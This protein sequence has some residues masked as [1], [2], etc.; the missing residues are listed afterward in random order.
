MT[1]S[2]CF[3][4]NVA[5]QN[6][7]S[8]VPQW[9]IAQEDGSVFLLLGSWLSTHVKAVELVT[10]L[11]L[12]L[13]RKWAAQRSK[14]SRWQCQSVWLLLPASPQQSTGRSAVLYLGR[15]PA[16]SVRVKLGCESV[17][18]RVLQLGRGAGAT[19]PRGSDVWHS[20]KSLFCAINEKGHNSCKICVV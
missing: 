19:G 11:L 14:C 1:A 7:R 6:A 4:P 20:R 10:T 18:F 2:C 17:S 12:V 3:V 8:D 15:V 5:F 9:W 16:V 13:A